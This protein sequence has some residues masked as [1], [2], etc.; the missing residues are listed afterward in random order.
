MAWLRRV[1]N[2][3]RRKALDDDVDRELSFHLAERIDQLRAEGLSDGDARRR[4][5]LQ[6]GNPLLQRERTIE[7]DV[8]AWFDTLLRNVRYAARGMVRTPGLTVIVVA[9]LA[10]GIGANTAMFSA[11]DAVVLQPLPFPDADRLVQLSQVRDATRE[12]FPA[13]ARLADWGRRSTTFAAMANYVSE[14]VS[15][16]TGTDPARIRRTTVGPRFLDVIGIAPARGRGF[17]DAEH[18]LGGPRVALISD[19]Y[20]RD[21]FDRDP[22]VLERSIR[23]GTRAYAVVGVLPPSFTFPDEDVDWWVPQLVDAPWIQTREFGYASIGRL[24][25]G[26]SLERAA[27][28]LARVQRQLGAELPKTDAQIRPRVT[29][30][31]ETVIGGISGSLWLLFG[32]VSVLLL[33]ACTNVASL[34]LSR[35]AQRRQEVA[36]RYALG[37]S[38]RSVVMQLLTESAL[39][40]IAGGAAG[41]IVGISISAGL[42][43]LAPTLPRLDEMTLNLRVLMY[44]GAATAVV[45]VLCGVV[46]AFRGTRAPQRGI[47]D[48]RSRVSGRQPLQWLLVGVQVALSVTLLAGAG[49][50]LRSLDALSRV[51]PGFDAGSVL[52]FSITGSFGEDADYTRTV[53]RINRTLDELAAMPGIEAAATTTIVPGLPNTIQVG[54]EL[55]ELRHQRDRETTAEF[56]I[57]SPSYFDVMRIPVLEGELCRQPENSTGVTEVMVNR[58]FVT[59][60]IR[61]RSALGLHLAGVTPDRIVGVVGDAREV[62]LD[63]VPVPTVYQCFSAPTPIPWF[64]ARTRGEPEAA[65]AAVR[66]KLRQLEP[67]RSMYDSVP[68]AARIDEAYAQNRLRTIVLTLFAGTALLLMCLGVYGTLSYVVSLRRREAGLRVALGASRAG[69]LRQFVGYAM[70]VVCVAVAVGFFLS[71]LF[72]TALSGMLFGITALDPLTLSTVIALVMAVASMAALIPAARAALA[73]PAQVLRSE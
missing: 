63:R 61:D 7:V 12:T 11:I 3:W 16:T 47:E 68:L 29:P 40:A 17:T 70:R 67:L 35:G 38:R 15:D 10:V 19:R 44:T 21:Q 71:I 46:P 25:S 23:M 26:V 14:D 32:A 53:Q 22:R 48:G 31:K 51:D 50:L 62:G 20:W 41:V 66:A 24:K 34:L 36:I 73:E 64:L 30:L 13:S 59:R 37:G 49:L 6:F 43:A 28:D 56:R 1:V 42:R 4:A 5:R 60:F 57:V 39:M 65:V 33:I 45:A 27:A 18:R 54:F 58:S 69:I 2:T 52:T 8:A 72:A 9:T 55:V